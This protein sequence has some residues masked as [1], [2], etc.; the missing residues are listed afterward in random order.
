MY[1]FFLLKFLI[2]DNRGTYPKITSENKKTKSKAFCWIGWSILFQN[3]RA[4]T[5]TTILGAVMKTIA[6]LLL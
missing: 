1:G 3:K 2:G 4:N 6:I 5:S